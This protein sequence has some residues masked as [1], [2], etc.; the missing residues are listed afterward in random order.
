L[1]NKTQVENFA[2]GNYVS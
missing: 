2:C 1:Q